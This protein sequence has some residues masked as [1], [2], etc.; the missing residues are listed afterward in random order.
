MC[1]LTQAFPSGIV[2]IDVGG[3]I[4]RTTISTVEKVELKIS[5]KNVIFR[6]NENI[7]FLDEDPLAFAHILRYAR[8]G[9]LPS[10]PPDL[11]LTLLTAR[12][13]GC[14]RLVARLRQEEDHRS[15]PR[16]TSSECLA[17]LDDFALNESEHSS[18]SFEPC[19][20]CSEVS[21]S[22]YFEKNPPKEEPVKK[23]EANGSLM[24]LIYPER[25]PNSKIRSK[26]KEAVK[27]EEKVVLLSP[28]HGT[29]PNSAA[30]LTSHHPTS[31][32]FFDMRTAKQ[33]DCT[34]DVHNEEVFQ[35]VSDI[36]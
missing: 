16:S 2:S 20:S 25:R 5:R 14:R 8:L 19:T 13:L 32:P 11:D 7:V 3:K 30:T 12:K 22:K 28:G 35:S 17:S 15:S 34:I 24:D 31:F 10:N 36:V 29:P 9:A 33:D 27:E 4:F 26:Q 23:K 21:L 6:E 18:L 1:V